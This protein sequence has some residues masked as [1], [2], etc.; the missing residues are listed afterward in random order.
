MYK[1]LLV[2]TD[3]SKLSLKAA[4]EAAKLAGAGKA[5]VTALYVIAPKVRPHR[6]VFPWP[7]RARGRAHGQ[8]DDE[9]PH[10]LRFRS[11]S[12][13]RRVRPW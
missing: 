3:G 10:A 9:G 12:A 4:K 5:K 7:P 6:H 13:A 1:H 8:R 2:P 11:W